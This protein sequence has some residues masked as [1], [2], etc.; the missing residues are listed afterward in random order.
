MSGALFTEGR[1]GDDWVGRHRYT[2]EE[3]GL[4]GDAATA[5]EIDN[6]TLLAASV[7]DA[8]VSLLSIVQP[9]RDRQF[10][11]SSTGLAEPV[12][13]ERQTPLSHSFCQHVVARG[14]V[15]VVGDSR[16]EPLVANNPSVYELGVIAY[17]GTPIYKHEGEPIGA[18]CV[19][20]HQP[21][22]WTLDD[23]NKLD[24]LGTCVS[25]AIKAR[26]QLLDLNRLHRQVLSSAERLS[27]AVNAGAVGLWEREVGTDKFWVSEEFDEMHEGAASGWT[28]LGDLIARFHPDDRRDLE[29]AMLGEREP[30]RSYEW[31]YRYR[32]DDGSYRWMRSTSTLLQRQNGTS[33]IA[34]ATVD[35][36]A[37]SGTGTETGVARQ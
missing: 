1:S 16:K 18:L 29:D 13:S 28:G 14:Q 35:I 8:P 20:E 25:E 23:A 19:I 5:P 36:T 30:G 11:T 21:R 2:V 15:L 6:L 7:F 22:V 17:L 12:K 4:V 37:H 9:E 10:F 27:S 26:A 34:G 31:V 33:V 24:R 32:N 3:L